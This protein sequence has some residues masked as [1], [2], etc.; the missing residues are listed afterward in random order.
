MS[1]GPK[2]GHSGVSAIF[3][4]SKAVQ[5]TKRGR[6]AKKQMSSKISSVEDIEECAGSPSAER[7]RETSS[8]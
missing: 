3:V 5:M 6:N 2:K 4:I 7:K 1:G 8:P